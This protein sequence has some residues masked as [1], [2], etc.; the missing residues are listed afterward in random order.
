[1]TA[2]LND[3]TTAIGFEIPEN[4]FVLEPWGL[5]R[6][7]QWIRSRVIRLKSLCVGG[8]QL[9]GLVPWVMVRRIGY[10][11]DLTFFPHGRVQIQF[12]NPP[13]SGHTSSNHQSDFPL[14]KSF[15]PLKVVPLCK[16][17]HQ[18]HAIPEISSVLF[19]LVKQWITI[20]MPLKFLNHNL[21]G[22]DIDLGWAPTH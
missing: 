1:V 17:T 5:L 2:D 18:F 14:N 8:F 4:K 19:C 20:K 22:K 21:H 9:Q 11:V 3:C 13:S 15:G 10:N 12:L 16:V 6:C 7:Q